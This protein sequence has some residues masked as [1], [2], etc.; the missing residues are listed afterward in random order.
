[1]KANSQ[2][3]KISSTDKV[4]TAMRNAGIEFMEKDDHIVINRNNRLVAFNPMVYDDDAI[5][6]AMSAGLSIKAVG[7]L[8]FDFIYE[9]YDDVDRID[10][11][12]IKSLKVRKRFIIRKHIV[13]FINEYGANERRN[14]SRRIDVFKS[15][16]NRLN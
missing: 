13:D 1:M 8:G 2:S 14:A 3:Q 4:K 7:S 11:K 6:L 16:S 9:T 15:M 12:L 10:V 5:F